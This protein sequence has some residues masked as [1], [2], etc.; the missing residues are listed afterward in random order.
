MKK[1]LEKQIIKEVY[2]IETEKTIGY[3]VTRIL[4]VVFLSVS[5][6][7]LSSVTFDVLN[8]QSSF[9][10]VSFFGENLETTQRYFVTN[11]TDFYQELPQPLFTLAVLS[12]VGFIGMV[13]IIVKNYPKIK[14]KVKSLY[15]FWFKQK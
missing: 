8:E 15:K 11:V 2:R 12:A 5:V 10:L 4:L 13:L 7:F 14:N 1:E 9:D 3:L 6:F